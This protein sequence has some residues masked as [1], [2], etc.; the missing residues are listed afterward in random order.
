[1][2][3]MVNFQY[4]VNTRKADKLWLNLGIQTES[5]EELR[6]ILPERCYDAVSKNHNIADG[7]KQKVM[8]TFETKII[9]E[10]SQNGVRFL[11]IV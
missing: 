8:E 3:Y 10:I 5:D 6:R 11:E 7:L 4:K 2:H 9:Q 1:M